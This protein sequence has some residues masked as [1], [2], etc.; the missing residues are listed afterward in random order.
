MAHIRTRFYERIEPLAPAQLG[1]RRGE[2]LNRMV[3]DV[4]ALQASYPRGVG[5]PLVAAVAA[6]ASVV[7][8][9]TVLPAAAAILAA[10]LLVG[11]IAVPLLAWALRPVLRPLQQAAARGEVTAELVELLRGA[12]ELVAYGREDDAVERVGAADAELVRLGR[13][14]ALAAGAADA[15]RDPGRGCERGRHVLAVAVDAYAQRARSTACSAT[16]ALL[17]RVVRRGRPAPGG[18]AGADRLLARRTARPRDR[19]ARAASSCAIRRSRG[20]GR[21]CRRPSPSKGVT[22]RYGAEEP[23]LRSL[24]YGWSRAAGRPDRPSGAT[25]P[26]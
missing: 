22:A 1:Y 23:V 24:T 9:A 16:L 14:D 15:L 12:P 11:G 8:A 18:G 6:G 20:P 21:P 2:L 7:A 4:D 13:R 10:G 26:R 19:R 3:G 25:R 5:P 17:A